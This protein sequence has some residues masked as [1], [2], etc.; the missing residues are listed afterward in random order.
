M[1]GGI[2]FSRFVAAAHAAVQRNSLLFFF[3]SACRK[4]A[5]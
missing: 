3:E 5:R 2:I 4:N 1:E